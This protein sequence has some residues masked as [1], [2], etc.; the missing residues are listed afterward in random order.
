[1]KAMSGHGPIWRIMVLAAAYVVVLQTLLLPLTVVASNPFA[2]TLCSTSSADGKPSPN[3][4]DMPCACASGCGMQC[5]VPAL[6]SPPSATVAI[7]RT[8][9]VVLAPPTIAAIP[10]FVS[11]RGSQNP[12]APPPL[13]AA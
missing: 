13:S 9:I 6:L 4:S 11:W 1:M 2:L 7:D 12:R 8:P 3:K 10:G 5:C